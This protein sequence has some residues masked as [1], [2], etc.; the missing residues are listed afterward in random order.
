MSCTTLPTVGWRVPRPT[1]PVPVPLLVSVGLP[2]PATVLLKLMPPLP[3]AAML[4]L[5]ARVT[6]TFC[7]AVPDPMVSEPDPCLRCRRP[8]S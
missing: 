8:R 6:A 3:L 5:P 7:P 2:V 1:Y 4:W